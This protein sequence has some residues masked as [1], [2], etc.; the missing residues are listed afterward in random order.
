M[1][2]NKGKTMTATLRFPYQVLDMKPLVNS[3]PTNYVLVK[4]LVQA[5][6]LDPKSRHVSDR[7]KQYH[8]IAR[9]Y[10]DN[11]LLLNTITNRLGSLTYRKRCPFFLC[12]YANIGPRSAVIEHV[13]FYL[14]DLLRNTSSIDSFFF[15]AILYEVCWGLSLARRQF[16]FSH[17]NLTT[18]S[19]GI[20][21]T[22]PGRTN[23]LNFYQYQGQCYRVPT[24]GYVPKIIPSRHS[25]LHAQD[26]GSNTD[27]RHLAKSILEDVTESKIRISPSVKT[28]LDAWI[29]SNPLPENEIASFTCFRISPKYLRELRKKHILIH[30]LD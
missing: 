14:S 9:C 1:K 11:S 16:G 12:H 13:N 3:S 19:I 15:L 25:I 23:V 26:K 22:D 8:V 18:K 20:L 4:L 21:Q 28:M 17:R 27:L 10:P 24:G 7:D 5:N 29:H 30:H 2:T 6:P